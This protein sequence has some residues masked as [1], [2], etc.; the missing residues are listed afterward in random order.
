MRWSAGSAAFVVVWQLAWASFGV[1]YPS[2]FF[3][4]S[5]HALA[6]DQGIVGLPRPSG[7][8]PEPSV[9]GYFYTMYLFFFWQRW[10]RTG[11]IGDCLYYLMCVVMLVVS[12]S[13]TAYMLVGLFVMMAAVDGVVAWYRGTRRER[14]A[15]SGPVVIRAT[16]I[17]VAIF[18]LSLIGG[19]LWL[20]QRYEHT[21]VAV[22]KDQIAHKGKSESYALRS[23]AD[24]MSFRIFLDT[25]GL[26]AGLGSHRS[27]SGL[28]TLLAGSGLVGTLA[29]AWLMAG[30]IRDPLRE[31]EE[32]E[33]SK[34]LRWGLLGLLACHMVT[35][36]EFQSIPLWTCVSLITGMGLAA[37]RCVP[38]RAKEVVLSAPSL[39]AAT[40]SGNLAYGA[41]PRGDGRDR[42]RRAS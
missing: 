12:T 14:R 15:R 34:A 10:R 35:V 21:V 4:S 31:V 18:V 40:A 36:P 41:L 11:R 20:A 3:H 22:V 25:Y 32:A 7:P 38:T 5:V 33:T 29:F 8:F 17:V 9:L 27:S 26:G 13:T 23:N 16:H 24:A 6:W 28:L 1:W 2:G 42:H 39:E 37:P 30:V 19:A